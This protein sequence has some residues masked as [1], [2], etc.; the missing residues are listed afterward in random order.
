MKQGKK[1]QRKRLQEKQKQQASKIENVAFNVGQAL[2]KIHSSLAKAEIIVTL[3]V[4]RVEGLPFSEDD[5]NVMEEVIKML[6]KEEA[7]EVS[8]GT[9][10]TT[11]PDNE[12]GQDEQGE[13]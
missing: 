12:S 10:P 4:K 2:E 3:L 13:D 5:E 7:D 1:I 6:Q 8:A 11:E 9:D